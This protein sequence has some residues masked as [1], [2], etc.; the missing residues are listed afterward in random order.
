MNVQDKARAFAKGAHAGQKYGR[1]LYYSRHLSDVERA[2]SR[3]A[4]DCEPRTFETL[5]AAAWLHDTMED[6]RVDYTLLYTEFGERIANIVDAVTDRAGRN[7]AERHEATYPMVR[8]VGG[9]E[10]VLVK[11]ADRIANVEYS[12]ASADDGKLKMYRKEYADFQRLIGRNDN[13]AVE[14]KLW[15][16]LDTLFKENP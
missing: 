12:I 5:T 11:L 4:Q 2:L 1:G 6:T 10:A 3:F 13:I 16:H 8:H 14:R 15:E 7:R 9:D